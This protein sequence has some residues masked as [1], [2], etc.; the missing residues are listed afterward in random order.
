MATKK[1]EKNQL[2]EDA[3][4]ERDYIVSV[5]QWDSMKGEEFGGKSEILILQVGEIAGPLTYVGHQEMTT[6]LGDTTVHTATTK[7]G[8]QV[9]LPIQATFLRALDQAG[10]VRGDSFMVKRFEDQVKKKGKGAGNPM[11]IYGV[12]VIDRV[13]RA[14]VAA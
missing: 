8:E 7:S 12:K 1:D 4:A 14:P 11:A 5:E 3:L 6:D 2:V 13:P 10:V 9:R